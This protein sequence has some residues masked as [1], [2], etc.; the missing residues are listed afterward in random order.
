[1]SATPRS[2]NRG[3]GAGT[4]RHLPSPRQNR[5]GRAFALIGLIGPLF[6]VSLVVVLGLLWQGYE[7]IRQTQS[8][9]GAVDSPH[10]DLMNVAG[11]MGLGVTILAFATAYIL[12]VR[13]SVAKKLAA[14]LL[15]VG[16]LGMVVVG[17]FPCDAG[18]VDVT[19]TGELHSI[20]S[21]PAAVG[22]PAAAMLSSG[23]FRS[24][25]RFSTTWQL[26]SFW[27]GLLALASGPI[28]ALEFAGEVSG[29]LQRAAMW[30]PLLWITVVSWKLR[31]F[32]SLAGQ[33]GAS[34]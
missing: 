28:I 1:M 16:G 32:P 17:F 18:C 24:D 20:F 31:S 22:L 12:L 5:V 7:P 9:L 13:E 15:V 34:R 30:A 29:G 3:P 8:E 33:S 25:G 6:Y 27:L 4:G 21:M 10:G 26:V 14:A 23:A 2:V 19:R 11:F